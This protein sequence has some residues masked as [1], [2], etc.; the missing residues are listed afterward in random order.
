MVQYQN[1]EYKTP[2]LNPDGGIYDNNWNE[3]RTSSG[4]DWGGGS[5]TKTKPTTVIPKV[6][7]KVIVNEKT[8]D[9]KRKIPYLK[10]TLYSLLGL[11]IIGV[12]Y[13]LKK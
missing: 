1:S 7:P 12:I 5:I 9:V 4:D 2:L 10:I 8:I 3:S 6:I 11:S 13:K